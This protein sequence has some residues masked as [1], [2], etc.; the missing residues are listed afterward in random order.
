[1]NTWNP[2]K[3]LL[4]TI[5]SLTSVV[6]PSAAL[7]DTGM[8]F[9]LH[10]TAFAIQQ[11]VSTYDQMALLATIGSIFTTAQGFCFLINYFLTRD[12]DDVDVMNK[13]YTYRNS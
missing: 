9:F 13:T 2:L 5:A 7:K 1:M 6:D 11:T 10:S 8:R 12:A 4:Q 3:Y